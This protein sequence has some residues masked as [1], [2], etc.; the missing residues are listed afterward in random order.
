M[1]RQNGQVIIEFALL[2]PLFI[3]L[4]FGIIYCGMLFY[5]YISLSNLARSAA[6]E[7]AIV[8]NFDTKKSEIEKYYTDRMFM[9][10]KLYSA[11]SHKYDSSDF[12][13]KITLSKN[14][15]NTPTDT[16]DDFIEVIITMD[17]DPSSS[18]LMKMILPD[19]Y[20]IHYIMRRD[21]Q[22]TTTTTTTTTTTNS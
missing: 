14:D 8:Q 6:R 2:L 16:G 19:N 9:L 7:A 18:G 13:Y 17:R 12:E 5:D 22:S 11:H 3:F 4:L 10:T 1:K 21:D 20:T 15:N